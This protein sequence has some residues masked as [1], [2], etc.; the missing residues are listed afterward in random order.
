MREVWIANLDGSGGCTSTF[1]IFLFARYN[2]PIIVL[3]IDNMKS[4]IEQEN[5]DHE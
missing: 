1:M 4:K 5:T 3:V 2:C